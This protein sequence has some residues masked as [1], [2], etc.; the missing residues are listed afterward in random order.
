MDDSPDE[1]V[2]EPVVARPRSS[3]EV[4][5]GEI[6]PGAGMVKSIER[7]APAGS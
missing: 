4:A 1:A 7:Q 5:P 6:I 3:I 2:P